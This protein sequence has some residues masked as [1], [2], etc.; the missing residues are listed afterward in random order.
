VHDGDTLK[1]EMY[2]MPAIFG[3]GIGVRL[4]GIDTPELKDKDPVV[5]AWALAAKARLEYYVKDARRVTL[6]DEK[7]DKYFRINARLL[8]DG[9]DVGELLIK[10]KYAKPYNGGKKVPWTRADVPT[11]K[12]PTHVGK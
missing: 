10:E 2:G 11:N 9:R 3:K 6:V 7:R 4:S 1:V 8:V 5:K 12:T